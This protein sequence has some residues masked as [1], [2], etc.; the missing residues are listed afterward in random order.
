[1]TNDANW[2]ISIFLPDAAQ[3][4]PDLPPDQATE[5]SL[6][7]IARAI[8]RV[9]RVRKENVQDQWNRTLDTLMA[10]GSAVAQKSGEWRIDEI[11]V[12]LT[13]SAK[14]ELLFI[15]EA[16]AEASIKFTLKPKT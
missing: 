13:L 2:E 15:A 10:L 7:D 4:Y 1:M 9:V 14:G 5:D 8:G 11:E 12:G 6:R 16:G 3:V